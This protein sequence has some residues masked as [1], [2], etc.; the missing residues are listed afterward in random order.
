[1]GAR[2]PV[3][4]APRASTAS[5][6]PLAFSLSFV[7]MEKR[8]EE[9]RERVRP[10]VTLTQRRHLPDLFAKPGGHVGRFGRFGREHQHRAS[11]GSPSPNRKH[12]CPRSNQAVP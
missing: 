11:P 3:D 6:A 2:C 9:A 7:A 12:R 4:R 5:R 10:R 1:M 8:S